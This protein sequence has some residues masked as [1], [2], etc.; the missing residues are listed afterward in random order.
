MQTRIPNA[1]Y[2]F[3]VAADANDTPERSDFACYSYN[4]LGQMPD[5]G[6]P[7]EKV[8][9]YRMLLVPVLV[10]YGLD[11]GSQIVAGI[12]DV[13]V[14]TDDWPGLFDYMKAC[15]VADLVGGNFLLGPKLLPRRRGRLTEAAGGGVAVCFVVSFSTSSVTVFDSS[16]TD[17]V[18]VDDS[19]AGDLRDP[20]TVLNGAQVV[21]VVLQY[22]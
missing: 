21:V 2:I 11:S 7:R 15:S 9:T 22:M 10:P 4:T 8:N 12:V 18:V 16:D 20:C 17:L 3:A 5:S 13:A 14:K 1:D 6:L 19:S